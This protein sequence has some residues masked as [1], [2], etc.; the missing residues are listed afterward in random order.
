MD[1]DIAL[2]RAADIVE[3]VDR[4]AADDALLPVPVREVWVY[5]DVALGLDPVERLDVYLTKDVLVG[6]QQDPEAAER[7]RETH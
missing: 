6:N 2:D 3:L 7:F 4:A 1:R 5:G